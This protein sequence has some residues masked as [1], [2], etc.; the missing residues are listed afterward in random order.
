MSFGNAPGRPGRAYLRAAISVAALFIAS[1]LTLDWGFGRQI[2]KGVGLI[3]ASPKSDVCTIGLLGGE[4]GSCGY[5]PAATREGKN[6]AWPLKL[7]K[8]WEPIPGHWAPTLSPRDTIFLERFGFYAWT[9]R[10]FSVPG[11]MWN[12]MVPEWFGIAVM[13]LLAALAG[14]PLWTAIRSRRRIARGRCPNCG[15]DLR[16]SPGRCPECGAASP[17]GPMPVA[18]AK[19]P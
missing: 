18:A 7:Q 1:F 2:N 3:R 13:L 9:K 19:P 12:I 16:G 6:K 10:G 17:P 15:Y 14:R 5:Q 11:Y 4:I 8:W